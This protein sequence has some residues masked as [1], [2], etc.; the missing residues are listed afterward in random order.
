MNKQFETAYQQARDSAIIVR[1]TQPGIIQLAG[2]D[3]LSFLHR[4]STNTVESMPVGWLRSTTLTTP[5][6]RIIDR[7]W[8]ITLENNL[9]V[10][11]STGRGPTVEAWLNKHIFFND[12][13]NITAPDQEFS[14]WGVYGP[15]APNLVLETLDVDAPPQP[16]RVVSAP[17]GLLLGWEAPAGIKL[18]L[19]PEG[20]AQAAARWPEASAQAAEDV[21]ETLRVEAGL[22]IFGAE[23]DQDS[24]PLEVGLRPTV[25]FEKGCYTGQEII[26][27]M[28][29]RGQLARQLVGF[30]LDGRLEP[31]ALKT[32][33]GQQAGKL[34]SCAYSPA[35]GWIGLGSVPTRVLEQERH[36]YLASSGQEVEIVNLPFNKVS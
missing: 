33:A 26:A 10:L 8:L 23:F 15:E 32:R 25:N 1:H 18:L 11:T 29:S 31:G 27:R 6:A 9:L 17:G 13:V 35:L 16:G 14:L 4:M 7:L 19:N 34:T 22:P 24:I 3:R 2:E 36:L 12:D 20:Q 30:R 28:D 21:F 5:L